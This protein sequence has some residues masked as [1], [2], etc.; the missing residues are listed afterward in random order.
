MSRLTYREEAEAIEQFGMDLIRL[1]N[2][3]DKLCERM[4][5][6]A[7]DGINAIPDQERITTVA[8]HFLGLAQELNRLCDQAEEA[9]DRRRDNP[10]EPDF[11][12][13]GQ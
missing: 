9:E 11:R 4:S 8:A 12:R 10:L 13:L 7:V 2:A 5:P 3:F 1:S 6:G